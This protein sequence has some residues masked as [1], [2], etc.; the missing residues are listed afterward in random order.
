M[1][2]DHADPKLRIGGTESRAQQTGVA[3]AR[4]ISNPPSTRSTMPL[5]SNKRPSPPM[6]FN[7]GRRSHDDHAP[8]PRQ[9]PTSAMPHLGENRPAPSP[10][11][12]QPRCT[13][14]QQ[15]QQPGRQ[16]N[17]KGNGKLKVEHEFTPLL[18]PLHACTKTIPPSSSLNR[19]AMDG[20]AHRA[21]GHTSTPP[22]PSRSSFVATPSQ[23]T[24]VGRPWGAAPRT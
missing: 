18:S 14:D 2:P 5:S 16:E 22:P 15:K 6:H 3:H 23:R 19:I 17:G 10:L 4:S 1:R 12:P 11:P 8:A 13:Q 20:R 24:H 9:Q 7:W 21:L